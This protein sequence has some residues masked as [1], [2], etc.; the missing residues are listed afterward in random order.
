MAA[1]FSSFA[2]ALMPQP[3]TIAAGLL[4]R[5]WW[6]GKATAAPTKVTRRNTM[7]TMATKS[8][9]SDGVKPQMRRS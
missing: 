1:I 3:R 7:V 4:E 9:D 5:M 8:N 6:R 2:D